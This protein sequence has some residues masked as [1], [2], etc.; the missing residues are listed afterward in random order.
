MA[1]PQY[2]PPINRVPLGFLDLLGLKNGGR[3]PASVVPGLQTN[4]DLT[5]FYLSAAAE[6]FALQRATDLV[7]GDSGGLN[8]SSTTPIDLVVGGALTVPNNEVW[9]LLEY[10]T[11][12]TF[13]AAAGES[14]SVAPAVSS[15][16]IG[17]AYVPPCALIGH[18]V[19]VAA[20]VKLGRY[21]A[22]RPCVAE[23]GSTLILFATGMVTATAIPVSG[24]LRMVRLR[25]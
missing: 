7:N 25:V 11:A 6:R 22:S 21:C 24:R 15:S 10:E 17:A 9:L 16:A 20:S 13:P 5:D 4:L 14:G 3:N 8:W 18:T 19:S 23:P 12:W 2:A 1:E